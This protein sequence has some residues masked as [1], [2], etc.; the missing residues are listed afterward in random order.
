MGGARY[1]SFDNHA[2]GDDVFAACK[3][4]YSRRDMVS[5]AP[6]NRRERS[7]SPS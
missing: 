1:F 4:L 5:N 6:L 2:V 7:E 3:E